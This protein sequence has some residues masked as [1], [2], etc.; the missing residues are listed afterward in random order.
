MYWH[1][2]DIAL[3]INAIHVKWSEIVVLNPRV[4]EG[5]GLKLF[6]INRWNTLFALRSN[7]KRVFRGI[8]ELKR[9]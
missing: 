9:F 2:V 4:L 1:Y 6:W 7:V 8:S 3:V 5:V